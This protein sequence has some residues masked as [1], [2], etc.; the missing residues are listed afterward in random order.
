MTV[1]DIIAAARQYTQTAGSSWF[2]P[3]DELRSVNR[4]YR[5]I[6]KKILD[7]NDE[8]FIVEVTEL[9]TAL[10]YVREGVYEYTLP[11][12]WYR[13]RSIRGV[14]PSGE[15]G[16][17]RLDPKE[18]IQRDGYRYFNSKLRLFSRSPYTSF[19]IEYYPEPHEYT[20][21]T[22]NI[23]YPKQ[24]EPLIIAYQIAIDILKSQKGDPSAYETEYAKLWAR[25]AGDVAKRDD[26]SYP[27]VANVYRSTYPGW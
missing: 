21:T 12:D 22:E 24:L 17:P 8:Y 18:R 2:S 11:S 25:F 7:Q 4:A 9:S 1:A 23:N 27:K 15:V 6:Y 26:Y 14:I 16:L 13:L 19:I 3:A 10:T 5:D 20:L